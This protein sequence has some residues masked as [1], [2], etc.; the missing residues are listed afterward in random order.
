MTDHGGKRPGAGRPV[1]PEADRRVTVTHRLAAWLAAWLRAQEAPATELIEQGMRKAYKLRAPTRKS[2][3]DRRY[4]ARAGF[5]LN[6]LGQMDISGIGDRKNTYEYVSD[7]A[8]AEVAR[9]Y[10]AYGSDGILYWVAVRRGR[11]A[12]I[13]NRN[14]AAIEAIRGREG[15]C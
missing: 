7:D 14:R 5:P 15:D 13:N 12:M 8:V 6:G 9:L 10:R 1:I 11:L 2:V 4:L 3:A